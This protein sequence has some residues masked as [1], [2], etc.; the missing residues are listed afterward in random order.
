MTKSIVKSSQDF[1]IYYP[2]CLND[3]MH[4]YLWHRIQH[5]VFQA[6]FLIAH[7]EMLCNNKD[8]GVKTRNSSC[9]QTVIRL[10][11]MSSS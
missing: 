6:Y 10:M 2:Q 7:T 8:E 9:L 1:W 3:Y 4:I 11:P 5:N